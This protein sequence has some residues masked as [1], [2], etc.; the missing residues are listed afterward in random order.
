MNILLRN[1]EQVHLF[2]EIVSKNNKAFNNSV[3]NHLVIIDNYKNTCYLDTFLKYVNPNNLPPDFDICQLT[4]SD[5][6]P[7]KLIEQTN[8]YYFKVKKYFLITVGYILYLKRCYEN[9]AIFK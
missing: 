4:Y 3:N 7:F 5:K 6:Q 8:L 9:I 1:Y 2:E